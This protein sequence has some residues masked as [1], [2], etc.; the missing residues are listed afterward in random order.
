MIFNNAKEMYKLICDGFDLYNVNTGA[1]VFLYSDKG[2]IAVYSFDLNYAKILSSRAV[3]TEEYW[4]AALGI[5]GYIYENGSD[6]EWCKN[7]YNYGGWMLT[8]DLD[9]E[10]N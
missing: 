2:S 6:M 1:Y 10:W 9:K 8:D 5:G 4:G 7:N 3:E